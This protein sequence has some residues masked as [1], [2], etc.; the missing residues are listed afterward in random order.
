M[1]EDIWISGIDDGEGWASVIFSAGG[2]QWDIV[3]L[4]EYNFGLGEGSI[5]LNLAF[6]DGWAV[7]GEDDEFGLSV[8]E[9]SEGGLIP[10]YVLATFDDERK[11]AVNIL[12]SSF[13][14]HSYDVVIN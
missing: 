4:V 14:S 10:E 9:G 2:S 3:S 5:V 8:S 6:S 1:T 13:F 7:I 11:L 12:D